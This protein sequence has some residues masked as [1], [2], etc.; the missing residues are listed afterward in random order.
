MPPSRRRL[1]LD[2]A[3]RR[4]AWVLED[5]YDSEYRYA[6]RPLGALQGMDGRGRVVYVGTCSKVLFPS[7][8]IGY[9][10][11]PPALRQAAVDAREALDL[12]S[13]P[14]YQLAL[15]DFLRE[16]GLARHVRRMRKVY[17]GRRH[18]LLHGLATHC[19]GRLTV[20]D[21]DAGLHVATLLPEGVDDR[22]VVER[23]ARHS[24]VATPLSA[25]H[26]GPASRGGLLLGFG[27]FTEARLADATRVLGEVLRD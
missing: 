10:V 21:A 23:M 18:A 3:E 5:D 6:G 9:L 13:P 26:A 20:L 16:G 7:I 25:C 22:P 19:A 15:A 17:L 11:V 12:F 14:L 4:D 2:W 8:R 1:L 24:L 27:G